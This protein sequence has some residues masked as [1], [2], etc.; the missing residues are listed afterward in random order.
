MR[1]SMYDRNWIE[2][3]ESKDE[4]DYARLML[5]GA[6]PMCSLSAIEYQLDS[7][8]YL[9]HYACEGCYGVISGKEVKLH[10]DRHDVWVQDLVFT[11][12]G[13]Q[14]ISVTWKDAACEQVGN[15]CC[16]RQSPCRLLDFSQLNAAEKPPSVN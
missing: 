3:A 14:D 2:R 11:I 9:R 7:R 8:R 4:R 12:A 6:S 1:T 13:E 15:P 5:S 16:H 10:N